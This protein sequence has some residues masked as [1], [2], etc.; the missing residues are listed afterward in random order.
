MELFEIK[1]PKHIGMIKDAVREA[2]L[3]GAFP[4]EIKFAIEFAKKYANKIG[5]LSKNNF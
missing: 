4:N 5:V 2:I 1:N 3:D